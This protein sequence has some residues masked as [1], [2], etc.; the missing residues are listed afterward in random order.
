M[1]ITNTTTLPAP[2][3]PNQTLGFVGLG[4][5]GLPMAQNLLQAGYRLRVYNRTAEKAEPLRRLGAVVCETPAEVASGTE[6]VFS[7]LA[8]DA[9]LENATAGEDGLLHTLGAGG[10]HLSCSTISP[11]LA[12]RLSDLHDLHDQRFVAAPVYGRPPVAAAGQ[13][14]MMLSGADAATRE[15]VKPFLAPLSKSVHDFGDAPDAANVVKVCGN[16]MIS[17]AI[18]A[19]G[20]AFTLAEKSG[21]NRQDVYAFLTQSVF[22]CT[23]YQSY[24]K[25]IAAE[26]YEP[27]GFALPLGLKDVM[28][29]E[30][31]A[32]QTLTPLPLAAIVRAHLIAARAKGRDAEDWSTLAREVSESAGL[33]PGRVIPPGR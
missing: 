29:A 11:D 26:Q 18:E 1:T 14:W 31:L 20:E 22:A 30:T 5:M 4:A 15:R 10:V 21:V 7:M 32:A 33:K 8:D 3:K 2:H 6:I 12:R 25:M 28:L 13:L 9:A 17:A 27:A 16:F 24:G 19:M 23:A